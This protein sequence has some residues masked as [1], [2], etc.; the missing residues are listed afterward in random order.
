MSGSITEFFLKAAVVY[1]LDWLILIPILLLTY[2]YVYVKTYKILMSTF[3]F[4]QLHFS[5]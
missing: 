2:V 5:F 3:I 1:F 4:L